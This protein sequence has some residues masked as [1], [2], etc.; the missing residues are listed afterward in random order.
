MIAALLAAGCGGG[1]DEQTGDRPSDAPTTT[2]ESTTTTLSVT[3][4][5]EGAFLAFN[6]LSD[7]LRESPDP[8]DPALAEL[9]SG[10]TLAAFTDALTTF[11]TTGWSA[12]FGER[13]AVHVLSVTLVDAATATLLECSVED[14]TEVKPSGETVGPYL[15]T[16]WT[17]WTLR[18]VDGSWRVDSSD[19]IERREG[20]HPCA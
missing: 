18:N 7:R 14:R 19:A 6:E 3:E 2:V 20:E 17:E 10:E 9:A 15:D 1:E 13:D 4:E 8:E 11:Q 12:R 5:V 16:Y